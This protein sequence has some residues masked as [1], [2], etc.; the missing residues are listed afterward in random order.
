[1]NVSIRK[2]RVSFYFRMLS[3]FVVVAFL[4]TTIVPPTHAQVLSMP[5][6]GSVLNLPVP[7]SFVPPTEGFSPALIKGITIHPENPLLFDFIVNS[8]DSDLQ[9]DALKNEAD[10]MI[11]Y[12]LAAL[13]VPEDEM[14][15]NLSPDEPDRIIPEGLGDTEMGRD[16][17]AQDYLLKQ[18]TASLMYPEEE[19]GEEFW[20][21]IY[22]RAYE[23]YGITD[24]PVD[25]FHKVWIVP[26]AA[27]VYEHE[28]SR[29]AFV[30]ESRLKVMLEADYLVRENIDRRGLIHQTQDKG[31]I[32]HARTDS[33][34]TTSII[35]D[36]LLPE[37]EREVNAG[38]TF[39]NLRQIYNAMILATWYKQKLKNSLLG[40]VYV[41]QNKTKGVDTQDKKITQKIYNQYIDSFKKGV[42][43]YIKEDYDQ[44]TQ[45]IVPRKYFSGGFSTISQDPDASMVSFSALLKVT[46]TLVLASVIFLV[47]VKLSKTIS[48]R[49]NFVAAEELK[50]DEWEGVVDESAYQKWKK[51]RSNEPIHQEPHYAERDKHEHEQAKVYINA[52]LP[53]IAS[54]LDKIRKM[55]GNLLS[56]DEKKKLIKNVARMQER[57]DKRKGRI[58]TLRM[59][60]SESE[61]IKQELDIV[62]YFNQLGQNVLNKFQGNRKEFRPSVVRIFEEYAEWYKFVVK[63]ENDRA[64][65]SLI[66]TLLEIDSMIK[67][68]KVVYEKDVVSLKKLFVVVLVFGFI[69]F[70]FERRYKS[71][72]LLQKKKKLKKNSQEGKDVAMVSKMADVLEEIDDD[73][74]VLNN[75][76]KKLLIDVDRNLKQAV[77]DAVFNE[78]TGGARE[79]VEDLT[80]LVKSDDYKFN[81]I[82]AVKYRIERAFKTAILKRFFKEFYS[83]K[84]QIQGYQRI[85]A[86]VQREKAES[87]PIIFDAMKDRKV[88]SKLDYRMKFDDILGEWLEFDKEVL[89]KEVGNNLKLIIPLLM[90]AND[91]QKNKGGVFGWKLR[92]V[93]GE[94]GGDRN[95]I[96]FYFKKKSIFSIRAFVKMKALQKHK[97]ELIHGAWSDSWDF[98]F[99][100]W[101]REKQGDMKEA[102]RLK[103]WTITEEQRRQIKFM[104]N[105]GRRELFEVLSPFVE[106]LYLGEEIDNIKRDLNDRFYVE[107]DKI[108]S[109][110][111]KSLAESKDVLIERNDDDTVI[112]KE[113]NDSSV[114]ENLND[115]NIKKKLSYSSGFRNIPGLWWEFS[116]RAKIEDVRDELKLMFQLLMD[117]EVL[118]K[119]PEGAFGWSWTKTKIG[120]GGRGQISLLNKNDENPLIIA[121][122]QMKEGMPNQIESVSK[123]TVNSD[124]QV[125]KIFMRKEQGNISEAVLV[126]FG[127]T[128]DVVIERAEFFSEFDLKPVA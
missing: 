108:L 47:G 73:I 5:T 67:E 1:M 106:R 123:V 43:D 110:L 10:K 7:G 121:E 8:G 4:T 31:M 78:S 25:T 116:K 83:K 98:G 6:A 94:A 34:I 61:I 103:F 65:R 15:V 115:S 16:L 81:R 17:L 74:L 109:I 27:T 54:D 48:I 77:N 60:N 59:N 91:S 88:R 69:T 19:L 36:I 76:K 52:M 89:S 45:E 105:K 44:A 33:N 14:W 85:K 99:K 2:R 104:K 122:I 35:R 39:A 62:N 55:M 41:D 13:T 126:R 70:F 29:S 75:R 66:D 58:N 53:G 51:G 118:N 92:I 22:E 79:I 84:I 101:F 97:I 102:V 93:P 72:F 23:E 24:I 125:F 49:T 37:I 71:R 57:F 120:E 26:E 32:N 80:D 20:T 124:P 82:V 87:A 100:M 38:T 68:L 117:T 111:Q 40:Q 64:R 96:I 56:E 11:K 12:F 46:T 18:L 90:D 114:K 113:I 42:Y 128:K 112:A 127:N 21:R 9:G 107:G 63:V 95:K 50:Y 30:V 3:V 28:E 86:A 119:E